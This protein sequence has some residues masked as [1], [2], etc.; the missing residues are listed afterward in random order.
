MIGSEDQNG[1]GRDRLVEFEV[2]MCCDRSGV[3]VSGVWDDESD[4][5]IFWVGA[6]CV[7]QCSWSE[8]VLV[9]VEYLSF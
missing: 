4:Q 2:G 9:A 8:R 5:G 7:R 3:Y 1:S 6:L